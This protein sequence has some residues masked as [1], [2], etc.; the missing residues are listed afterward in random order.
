MACCV[1]PRPW[2]RWR[3]TTRTAEW[4]APARGT[5]PRGELAEHVPPHAVDGLL[6]AYRTEG[7]KLA[8]PSRSVELAE[9]ALRGE[10]FP[11]PVL[12]WTRPAPPP[13]GHALNVD[14]WACPVLKPMAHMY[15]SPL[16]GT[17]RITRISCIPYTAWAVSL[18]TRPGLWYAKSAGRH[19]R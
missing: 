9:R 16:R 10:A 1:I 18:G 7:F 13:G 6:A 11:P 15:A 14:A 5:A 4:R 2:P 17:S 8:A 19:E 3:G 12:N